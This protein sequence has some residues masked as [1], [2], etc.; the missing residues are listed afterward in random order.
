MSFNIALTGLNAVSEKLDAVSNNIA[1]V[2][3]TGFKS[4]RTE[5]GSVYADSQAMGVEV[6]GNTQ[7]I[8]LG[9]SI[10]NTSRNLD[11]AISG[12]GFFMV[13]GGT[14]ETQ[15]TRAGVFNTDNAN[16]VVNA[17]GQRLQGYMTD[18]AGNLQSGTVGDLQVKPASLPAKATDAL[19]FVAN[20]DADEAVP[21]TT[22]FDPATKASYNS[23]YTTKIY[24]SQGKQHTL[25]QYFVKNAANDWTSNYY[26]DGTAAGS[27]ALT[28]DSAGMLTSPTTPT[29]LSV[30]GLPGGVA[31]LSIAVDFTGTTQYGSDFAVTTNAPT[32][33][34]SGDKTGLTV[35]DQGM[36]YVNYSNGER[37]LQ[38]QVVL[39]NFTNP[40]GLKAVSGTAWTET[41]SSG[42]ALVGAPGNGQF[43]DLVA[44][45]L[46][47]SNVDLTAQLVDLMEGQRN[48]QANT[49]VLTTDK[50]LTQA[51]FGAI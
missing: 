23:T 16:Y 42:S 14:G 3:T 51:L 31:P 19:T 13:K 49:K 37:L 44:G 43:G 29:T 25:T 9:G 4:S 46:E 50:E 12:A 18:A 33:Y 27:Q 39:A 40:Q 2:G 38:G 7:S 20:L 1:N 24:D 35:D 11:L 36:V 17:S 47:G 8:S 22:P 5:F 28:F 41:S 48:Y 30:A 6:L 15:Y 34:A 26:V 10:T 45:A 32:G 21:T